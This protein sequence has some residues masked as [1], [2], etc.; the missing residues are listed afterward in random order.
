MPIAAISHDRSVA[1]ASVRVEGCGAHSSIEA[2]T[3]V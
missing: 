3:A 1:F 2:T